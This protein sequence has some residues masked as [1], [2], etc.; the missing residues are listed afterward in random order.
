[1][2]VNDVIGPPPAVTDHLTSEDRELI[3]LIL[4]EFAQ[5]NPNAQEVVLNLAL[6]QFV[7]E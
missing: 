5:L 1:L 3:S 7:D 2:I 4:S 6:P